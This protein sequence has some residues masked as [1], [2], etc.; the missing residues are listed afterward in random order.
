[1][2]LR[3]KHGASVIT[4][5]WMIR[6]LE[7]YSEDLSART[8]RTRVGFVCDPVTDL[9]EKGLATLDYYT[10]VENRFYCKYFFY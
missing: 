10:G 9:A 3:L 2:A 5:F 4:V 1:M 6:L 7:D 8:V